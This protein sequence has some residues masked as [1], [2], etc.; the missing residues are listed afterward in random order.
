MA[1]RAD[2]PTPA[3]GAYSLAV[4]FDVTGTEVS[5]ASDAAYGE[6]TEY[7]DN[8]QVIQ[9]TYMGNLID[10]KQAG[11]MGP[12]TP[13]GEANDPLTNFHGGLTWDVWVDGEP[14][15]NIQS[16]VKALKLTSYEDLREWALTAM[17]LPMWDVMPPV[18]QHDLSALVE[19]STPQ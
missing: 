13:G 11:F 12:T 4:W 14:A 6:I 3:G 17:E 2:G 15:D 1:E 5:S 16:L 9:R 18:L 10:G 7:D 8:D 19:P